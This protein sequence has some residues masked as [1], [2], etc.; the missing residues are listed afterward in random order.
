MHILVDLTKAFDTLESSIV[1]DKLARNA[2]K[3]VPLNQIKSFLMNRRHYVA[4]NGKV[5]EQIK[6]VYWSPQR[7]SIMFIYIF[8]FVNGLPA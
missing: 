3:G 5:S 4:V 6:T 1:F 8:T 2:T 7:I